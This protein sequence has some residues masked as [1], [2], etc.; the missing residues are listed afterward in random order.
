MCQNL[1]LLV[2]L[3]LSTSNSGS[4]F[5]FQ[6]TCI[7]FSKHVL[8][9][10]STE[11]ILT[12]GSFSENMPTFETYKSQNRAVFAFSTGSGSREMLPYFVNVAFDSSCH[13]L[14]VA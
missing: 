6:V 10:A 2:R 5:W 8:V 9:F 13:F 11:M 7:F 14:E 3:F 1:E 4:S 12:F